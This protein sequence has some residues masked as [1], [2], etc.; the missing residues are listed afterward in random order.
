MGPRLR[1][2]LNRWTSFGL[3]TADQA[4]AIADLEEADTEQASGLLSEAIGY[5]GA[6]SAVGAGFLIAQSVW[7]DL[8]TAGRLAIIATLAFAMLA[9]GWALRH[10]KPPS[11]QRLTDVLWLGATA[12]AG[13]F[14]GLFAADVAGL[15]EEQ[16]VLTVGITIAVVGGAL[17]F[18][19]RRSLELISM[20][21]GLTIAVLSA[22]ALAVDDL[23]A[24]G[25]GAILWLIGAVFFA[26]GH[27]AWLAPPV[28]TRLIGLAGIAF[29]SQVLA[30]E[31][32]LAGAA[33]A[34]ASAGAVVAYAVR[35][36]DDVAL[37][38]GG[39]M[40]LLL[41]PQLVFAVFGRPLRCPG[42]APR[43][44]RSIGGARRLHLLRP[45]GGS[46]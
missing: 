20:A 10:Q 3:I 19:R 15:V 32:G 30:G 21:G 45:D 42:R 29:G 18:T 27:C 25:F 28:T 36:R 24:I 14:A 7:D 46:Q 1:H 2:D 4:Q 9:G 34:T 16:I 5:V 35:W 6:A 12:A 33:V 13:A 8:S 43:C 44:R 31:G 37:A 17:W 26:C 11:I 38:I 40:V 39:V 22:T 23:S 41:V